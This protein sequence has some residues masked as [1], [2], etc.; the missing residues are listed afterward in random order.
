MEDST[1]TRFHSIRCPFCEVYELE[2]S[3]DGSAPCSSCRRSLGAELLGTIREIQTLPDALGSYPCEECGHLEMRRLPDGVFHCS[4][5][6]SEVLPAYG[7]F[8]ESG[9]DERSVPLWLYG[10]LLRVL[11]ELCALPRS[12]QVEGRHRPGSR[13]SGPR[14]ASRGLLK[15][16]SSAVKYD[17]AQRI[18]ARL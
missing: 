10:G 7:S 9:G 17:P 18:A 16:R 4:A 6:G 2:C 11:S 1:T 12:R 5:C 13:S 3:G 15:Q 8:P 14:G